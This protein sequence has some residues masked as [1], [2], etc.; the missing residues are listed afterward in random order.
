MNGIK[1]H[2]S[3]R[4]ASRRW[5]CQP[6]LR[7]WAIPEYAEQSADPRRAKKSKTTRRE[8]PWQNQNGT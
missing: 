8:A 4:E 5:A 2:I 7:A 1:G 6:I 3:I